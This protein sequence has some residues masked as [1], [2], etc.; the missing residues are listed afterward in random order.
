V[1]TTARSAIGTKYSVPSLPRP[2]V[3]RPRV[4]S[5]LSRG[6]RRRFTVVSGLPGAGKTT[7]AAA[8]VRSSPRRQVAWVN[9]DAHDNEPGRFAR[10]VIGALVDASALDDEADEADEADVGP[11]ADTAALDATLGQLAPGGWT[12]VVDDA[13]ELRS[14]D[15]ISTLGH[16]FERSPEDLSM[17]LCT[18]ADPPVAVGRLR[19]SGRLGEIR[20]ADLEFTPDEATELFAA[21]GLVT[22]PDDVRALWS[23][24]GGW[25]AGLRLAAV[26]LEREPDAAEFVRSAT[27][28]EEVVADY[29]V[30]ELLAR[31]DEGTQRF[32]LRTS[33]TDHLTPELAAC[34]AGVDVDEARERLDRLEGTGVFITTTD[35][36]GYR[37]HALFAELL[38]ACLRHRHPEVVP[39]LHRRA[40]RWHLAAGL[41]DG[42][43][44]H[45]RAGGD[46]DL[47]GRLLVEGCVAAA[48]AGTRQVP[49]TL[50]GI[51]ADA[52]ASAPGLALVAAMTGCERGEREAA[53]RY[54]SVVDRLIDQARPTSDG[55]SRWIP[56]RAVLDLEHGW[57]FGA[58]E[59]ARAA[60]ACLRAA[61][62]NGRAHDAGHLAA[63]RGAE[64]D[65]DEGRFD[66]A[67]PV[68]HAL[69]N[70]DDGSW[71]ATE[72]RAMLALIDAANGAVTLA[73]PLVDG[74]LDAAADGTAGRGGLRTADGGA[75]RAA[76]RAAHLAAALCCSLR[77]EHR[78]AAD[79]VDAAESAGPVASRTLDAVLRALRSVTAG[80]VAL[81]AWLDTATARQ[82]LAE[83]ALVAA[84]VV[85]VI[86]PE[87]RLVVL[88]G[89]GERAVGRA[90]QD[91][92]VGAF[93]TARAGIS[94]WLDAIASGGARVSGHPRTIVEAHTL[95]AAATA[96]SGDV[97][98]ARQHLHETLDL[99]DAWGIRAP[100]LDHGRVLVELLQREASGLDH[101][102]LSMELLDRLRHAPAG[103]SVES[104]TDRET[105]VLQFLPTLMSNAE[106]ADG[107]HL[108]VNTVKSHLKA[109][110]R[111]LG[112]DGRREAVLRGRELELL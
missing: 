110:Y 28:T 4:E 43:E 60:P 29:L 56:A 89:P 62:A 15:A 14:A 75:G 24:T 2:F 66:A 50:D 102:A 88:G 58:D 67:A 87:R 42:A 46:W 98:R 65:V 105:T 44:A 64:L 70:G 78:N 27:A 45:A 41:L 101:G 35:P 95:A 81:A 79:H 112:V 31:Q 106:I 92:A 54:R 109:V 32:L 111:K 82:P 68:L 7:L 22:V 80:R 51:P 47:L 30:E 72:A 19:L 40:A 86:D 1:E 49:G 103:P 20:N 107:M 26:A 34:V 3:R 53:D 18:R 11:G 104:L 36:D 63:L 8:W 38:R 96:G 94:A 93:D 23:R 76:L 25:A 100:V 6:Q 33:I 74:L 69:A 57:A 37:H 85:E 52:I 21:H 10:A 71:I 13:H 61:A 55:S 90:R 5:L 9:L 84:G 39:E 48:L 12:L 83:S 17:V 91:L 97:V 73:E 99:V 59:R 108:S 16:L 77:G